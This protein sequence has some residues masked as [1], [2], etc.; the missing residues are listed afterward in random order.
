MNKLLFAAACMAWTAA[1]A[2][3]TVDVICSV[4]AAWCSAIAA[5]YA[6]STGTHVRMSLKGADDALVQLVAEAGRPG[7]D[8]WFGGAAAA[9]LAAAAQGLTLEHRSSLLAQLHPWAQQP[10]QQSGH[11]TVGLYAAPLGFAYNP[12]LLAGRKLPVPRTWADLLKPAYRSAI[13]VVDPAPGGPGDALVAALVWRMGRD[14]A[15]DYLE[16]L[17]RS[18]ARYT[19]SAA[20]PVKAVARGEAAVAI[21]F[22]HDAIAEKM[23]GLSVEVV[24]P[25]DGTGAEVGAMSLVKGARN[26][27]AARQFYEWALTPAAQALAAAQGQFQ[28]P[29]NMNTRHDPR[30]PDA[31]KLTAG[32]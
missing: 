10:A 31:G 28:V 17:D 14:K 13:Q 6:R 15:A 9:H 30:I 18:V 12:A 32:P 5:T 21:G 2:Q 1:P 11:R 22:M 16:A 20:G 19:R 23:Q 4:P 3:G 8:L 25:A 29:S 7:A 24:A 27:D 26:P